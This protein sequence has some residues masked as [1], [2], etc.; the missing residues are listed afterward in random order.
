MFRHGSGCGSKLRPL[1]CCSQL[2]TSSAAAFSFSLI[3]SQIV[4]RK[5]ETIKIK[6][7][8]SKI[9]K[10]IY[11]SRP[12]TLDNILTSLLWHLVVYLKRLSI[13]FMKFASRAC[14]L[15]SLPTSYFAPA[16][17]FPVTANERKHTNMFN[18]MLQFLQVKNLCY[19]RPNLSLKLRDG[20][21]HELV[22]Q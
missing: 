21:M 4:H 17:P 14:N 22:L 6:I 1:F 15:P 12:Q 10:D 5:T 13:K 11:N 3:Y 8:R 16:S 19:N 9:I 20:L 7:K 18:S 2:W